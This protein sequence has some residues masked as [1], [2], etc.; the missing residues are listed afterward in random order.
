MPSVTELVEFLPAAHERWNELSFEQKATTVVI[1][2]SVLASLW[3]GVLASE[4][5][6]PETFPTP[7]P[8]PSTP[9]VPTPPLPMLKEYERGIV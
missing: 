7:W 8:N 4:L 5:E 6:P 1:T 2:L 3:L 9:T